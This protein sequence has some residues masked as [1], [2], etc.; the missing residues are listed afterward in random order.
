MDLIFIICEFGERA[1][2]G[3]EELYNIV[4]MSNWY[5]FSIDIQQAL[6]VVMVASQRPVV[7]RGF[8]NIQCTRHNFNGVS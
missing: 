6:S 5:L 3:F 4:C 7:I 8:G 2:N 1:R